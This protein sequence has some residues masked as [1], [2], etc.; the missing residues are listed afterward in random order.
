[1]RYEDYE[2]S[3]TSPN[4]VVDG[5]PNAGTVLT[6]T[7]WPGISAPAGLARDLS[8]EMAFAYLDDPPGHPPAD[9]VT[10][11]HFDQDGLISIFALTRPDEAGP[12]RDLLIDIAAAG[13]FA[14]YRDRR[15]ARAAMAM[16]RRG[17]AETTCS[18]SEFTHQLY[19]DLLPDV[20]SM[21]LDNEAYREL[22]EEED[23]ELTASED[24]ISSGA[25]TI[26]ELV[27]VDLAVVR[28]DEDEPVRSGHRFGHDRFDGLHPMA[29]HNATDCFRL[30]VIHGQRYRYVDRYETWVQYQSRPTLPR[31]DMRPLAADL[32]ARELRSTVWAA[33]PPDALSPHLAPSAASSIAPNDVI[34]AIVERLRGDVTDE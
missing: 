2:A 4:I 32:S 1:M 24:A 5:S 30:L 11:N 12:H 16:A 8:A 23:D 9:L 15:A 20:L 28:I 17:A 22:W 31:V 6:L 33:G 18:Y 34:D 29:I 13:D 25:V 10:N 19:T 3:T 21:A 7:H 27:D 26:D 14:T